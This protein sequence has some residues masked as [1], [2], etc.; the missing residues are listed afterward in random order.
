[1]HRHPLGGAHEINVD[2]LFDPA[3]H[4]L[5]TDCPQASALFSSLEPADSMPHAERALQRNLLR[6]FMPLDTFE[7]CA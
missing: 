3:S 1:M 2:A 6:G 4:E 7:C 5:A